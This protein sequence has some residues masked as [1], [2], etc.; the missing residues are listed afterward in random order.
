MIAVAAGIVVRENKIMLCQRKPQANL[1]LKWE[2]PGGKLEP[3]ETPEQALERELMEELRIRTRTG[4]VYDACR[5]MESG[6]DLLIL[7]YHSEILEGEPRPVECS[8]IA[9]LLPNDLLHYE[10]APADAQVAQ[11]IVREGL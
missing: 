10:L 3:G 2:F 4:H 9:W 5:R 6:L 11:R 7:F 1:A 8:D